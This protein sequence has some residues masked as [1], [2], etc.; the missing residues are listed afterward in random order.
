MSCDCHLE[1][2]TDEQ[3][4]VLR[5]L[6]AVNATMFVAEMVVG[7]L[8]QSSGVIADSLDMA[9]DALVYGVGLYAIGRA[10]FVKQQA[11]RW[12][13]IVQLV[14]AGSILLDVVRRALGG[15]EPKSLLMLAIAGVALG[16]NAYCLALLQK[17]KHG[18]VH[19]RA[20]WIFSRSDV[21]A[22]LGVIAAAVLVYFTGTRWPDLVIG[23][24]IALVVFAGGCEILREARATEPR[25]S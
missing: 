1:P 7:V 4:A 21:I 13:G 11:A 2:E 20:S 15:S 8:A 22:N 25:S 18:E 16:A 14:L 24:A 3:R 12:S 17:H 23:A 10:P 6:L 19:M 5:I 9:A